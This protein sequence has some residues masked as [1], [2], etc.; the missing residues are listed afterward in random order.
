MTADGYMNILSLTLI[1]INFLGYPHI[2]DTYL[3]VLHSASCN[4]KV[5]KLLIL[6]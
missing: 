6:C 2:W 5:G 1:L 3:D 4:R